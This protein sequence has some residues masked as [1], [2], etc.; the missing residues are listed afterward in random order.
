MYNSLSCH[1]DYLLEIVG[2]EEIIERFW[3]WIYRVQKEGFDDISNKA[4]KEIEFRAL[5]I[6]DIAYHEPDFTL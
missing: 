6:R 1:Y 5:L 3:G 4:D 2:R